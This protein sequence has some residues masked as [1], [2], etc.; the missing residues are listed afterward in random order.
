VR[1]LGLALL[2]VLAVGVVV[3]ADAHDAPLQP[4]VP[5]TVAYRWQFLVPQWVVEHRVV[6]TPASLEWDAGHVDYALPEFAFVSRR[7]G[8]LPHFE[9]K[10]VDF[11][12]PNTCTTTWRDVYVDVP[13]A[14]VRYG[15]LDVDVPRWNSPGDAT[16][17]DVPHLE[18]KPSTLDVTLP[19]LARPAS[20]SSAD[21]RCPR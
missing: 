6:R 18:W 4:L 3:D 9:C 19:A 21:Q 14:G 11:W 16:I 20:T 15:R 1:A 12:L 8:S 13:V 7:I 5:T 2:V 17:V 10:Y